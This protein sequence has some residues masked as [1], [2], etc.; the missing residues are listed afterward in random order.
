MQ[1]SNV[2]SLHTQILEVAQRT[3]EPRA[4]EIP[5]FHELHG[6]KREDPYYWMRERDN[7]AVLAHLE[8][9]NA[10]L[11]S[12]FQPAKSL[13]TALYDEMLARIVQDD[14]TVPYPKGHYLY[15]TRF[16]EGKE[17]PVYCRQRR[18]EDRAA[19]EV[20]LDVNAL[21]EGHKFCNA[22]APVVSHDGT[23]FA[24]GLDLTGRN[25]HRPY[26]VDTR[27]GS[28]YGDSV[29]VLAGDFAWSP[30]GNFLYYN[31]KDEETL[32]PDR[33]WRHR[34]GSSFEED[35]LV[36][37][38]SDETL[39]AHLSLS[40]D[41]EWLLIHSG[42]TE[43]LECRV[44][45]LTLPGSP[46][47]CVRA[48]RPGIHYSV[49]HYDGRW[50]LLHN[51]QAPNFRLSLCDGDVFDENQWTPFLDHD[52]E[53]LIQGF[54]LFEGYLVVFERSGG[55][56]RINIRDRNVP[57]SKHYIEFRDTS[58]DC[59]LGRNEEPGETLLRLHYTS[60]TT[61]VSTFDYDMQQRKLILR[62][63]NPVRG[64]FNKENYVTEYLQVPA[65]DGTLIPVSLASLRTHRRDGSAPMVLQAYGSYGISYDPAFST[66]A[67]SLLNRGFVL[68][69]AHIRGGKEMGWNW[70][71]QG[72]LGHKMNSFYDFIDC[73]EHLVRNGY[74]SPKLLFAR[75]G[76]AGGLLMGAVMN[77]RPD[78]FCG[79]LANVPF[80]DVLTTMSDPGI[81][82]TTGEYQEWG[83]P[84]DAV[85]YGWMRAYS[86]YDNVVNGEYPHLLVTTGFSD[87]QVQYWEPAK[88]VARLRVRRTRKDRL[89]LFYTNLD[90][91]HGGASGRFERLREL[92]LE[93]AFAIVLAEAPE[94]DPVLSISTRSQ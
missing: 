62:K 32:R 51:D 2:P 64:G 16:L 72:R 38:E 36:Y 50:Y 11:E 3:P 28:R 90:A 1:Q 12:V 89:L 74:C 77:L 14:S 23:L 92:A 34:L 42:Y 25:L 33:I 84:A 65:R 40:R 93:Y 94:A 53:V 85:Q 86:P 10:Y 17:Y 67:L 58:Y 63:E 24:F 26:I 46:L 55:M 20:L 48:K 54:E 47:R 18:G 49:D 73:A 57:G 13:R 6:E 80:V 76:S 87:S 69:I 41:R 52:P 91:G 56:N 81:P 9:E 45:D 68:A 19:E 31:T 59:W 37:E 82:L 29:R 30:D 60:M 22:L 78:L 66:N 5:H 44:M 39:Y 27:N 75:G 79:I 4:A 70:Y 7:P 71:E 61:P 21:A 43:P 88:W 83:N 8:G 15:Y 35:Q